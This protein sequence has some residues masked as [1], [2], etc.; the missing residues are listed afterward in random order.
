MISGICS[1]RIKRDLKYILDENSG[2]TVRE[3]F[4]I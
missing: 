2:N 1:K 3:R 4:W